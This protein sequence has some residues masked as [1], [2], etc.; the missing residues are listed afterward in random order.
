MPSK[1]DPWVR[2]DPLPGVLFAYNTMVE[3]ASGPDQGKR[4]WLVTLE[5]QAD[6]IYTVELESG[7]GVNVA[8]SL[9]RAA[10]A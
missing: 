9:L 10:P 8:Q 5:L 2:G 4:G 3:I 7:E 6:P 1:P